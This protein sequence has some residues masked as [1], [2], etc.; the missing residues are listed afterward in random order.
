MSMTIK[1]HPAIGIARLGNS[2]EVFIGPQ[3]PGVTPLPPNGSYRSGGKILRQACEFR[4]YRHEPG[5]A[6]EELTLSHPDVVSI[7]WRVQVANRKA[8]EKNILSN[9]QLPRNAGIPRSDL[10]ISAEP[11]ELSSP[12]SS[13]PLSGG[14]FRGTAISLGEAR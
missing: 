12:G 6:P 10:I 7:E 13:A 1:I 5:E 14:A 3:I 9:T 8:A 2:N 4:V 11:Q